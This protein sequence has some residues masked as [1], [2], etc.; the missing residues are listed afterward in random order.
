MTR[1]DSNRQNFYLLGFSSCLREFVREVRGFRSLY[2]IPRKRQI[3]VL[4]CQP[5]KHQNETELAAKL[6]NSSKYQRTAEFF[7]GPF[8]SKAD[9]F[10]FKRKLWVLGD[11]KR[12]S[13][14]NLACRNLF[15]EPF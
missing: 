13:P 9:F 15:S 14:I 4:D 2:G 6:E 11:L 10:D 3:D 7:S 8:P 1:A 5:A 12:N